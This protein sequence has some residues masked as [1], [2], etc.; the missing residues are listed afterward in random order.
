MFQGYYNLTSGIL[1]QNRNL[2][3]ISNNMANVTTPGFKGDTFVASTFR[4]E[5]ISRTGNKD[6]SNPSALGTMAM[7]RAARQTVTDYTNQSFEP[8]KSN[9]DFAL[10]GN[11]FFSIQS[12]NG[13]VYTRNGSFTLDDQG[14]LYLPTIG[15]VLGDDGRPIH[16]GTDKIRVDS[17]GTIYNADGNQQYGRLQVVDFANYDAQLTKT[18]GNVFRAT[19]QATPV[20]TKVVGNALESS[21]VD[22]VGQMTQMM[23]SQRALQSSSQVMKMYDQLIGKM[24]SQLGPA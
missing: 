18:T 24:V 6:K 7:A 2:N 19:G 15:R 23:S 12:P 5:L 20:D 21:N 3:V 16:L 11:G 22:T 4:E 13:T 1:C 10:A 8:T 9:L 17:T 14:Y